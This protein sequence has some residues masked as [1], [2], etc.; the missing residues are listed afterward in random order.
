MTILEICEVYAVS[1]STARRKLKGIA[2]KRLLTDGTGHKI[3][4]WLKGDVARAFK[5][6]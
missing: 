1:D 2:P 3:S 6:K 5:A 4:D